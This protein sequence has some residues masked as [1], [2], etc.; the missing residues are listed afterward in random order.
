M[1]ASESTSQKNKKLEDTEIPDIIKEQ[2]GNYDDIKKLEKA[3][4]YKGNICPSCEEDS[5]EPGKSLCWS[6]N[7]K[8]KLGICT[9]C[10]DPVK[11]PGKPLAGVDYL[12]RCINCSGVQHCV[13]CGTSAISIG[14]LQCEACRKKDL[15]SD[16]GIR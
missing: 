5:I 9:S 4:A 16:Y 10:N 8:V 11:K 13:T 14:K 7:D 2:F 3:Y 15:E 1:V 12:G 6:C